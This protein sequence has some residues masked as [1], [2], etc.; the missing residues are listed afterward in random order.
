MAIASLVLGIVGLVLDLVSV[1]TLGWLGVIM[2]VVAIVLGA[3]GRKKPE[4]KGIATAGLVLGIL[5][6]VFG[7]IL[8]VSC[9]LVAGAAASG[10]SSLG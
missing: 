6:V 7:M 2:G 1:G 8:F 10:L 3:L 9:V 4:G 5:S